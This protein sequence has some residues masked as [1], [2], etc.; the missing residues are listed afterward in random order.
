[1]LEFEFN[2][3][4]VIRQF[5]FNWNSEFEFNWTQV[6]LVVINFPFEHEDLLC[7][8]ITIFMAGYKRN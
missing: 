4:Q 2:W 5:E 1:M 6:I 8:P 7:A 3:T